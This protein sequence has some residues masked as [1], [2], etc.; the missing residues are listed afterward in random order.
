[1]GSLM[2]TSIN[3]RD[4]PVI[5]AIILFSAFAVLACNL[6]VDVSYAYVDPRIRYE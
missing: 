3:A 2:M 5:M 4:Y 6:L 1:I